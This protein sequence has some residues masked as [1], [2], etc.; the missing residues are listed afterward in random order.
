MKAGCFDLFKRLFSEACARQAVSVVRLLAVDG[1][2]KP[3]EV[4]LGLYREQQRLAPFGMGNPAPR[5][6]LR[7]VA[8]ERVQPMGQGGEHLQLTVRL[9]SK[10]T[11]R[12]VWFHKGHAAEALRA[13]GGCFDVVFELTQNDFGGDSVAELRLVDMASAQM[14]VTFA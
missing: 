5:W 10:A 13:A 9:G 12:G 6:G 11:V 8:L 7:G 4:S 14:Q 3:E 2:L 1:W